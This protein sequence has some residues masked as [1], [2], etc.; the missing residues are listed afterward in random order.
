[1]YLADLSGVG[2]VPGGAAVRADK[3]DAVTV[4]PS[5]SAKP[6]ASC[7]AGPGFGPGHCF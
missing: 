5:K 6:V 2:R 4:V 1:M 7:E 3:D